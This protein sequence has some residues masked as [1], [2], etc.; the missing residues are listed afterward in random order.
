MRYRIRRAIKYVNKHGAVDDRAGRNDPIGGV[1]I[2]QSAGQVVLVYTVPIAVAKR[3]KD[4]KTDFQTITAAK[5]MTTI[6][7][8][9]GLIPAKIKRPIVPTKGWRM[10]R[11]RN[12]P[13]YWVLPSVRRE[14]FQ[15]VLNCVG[16]PIRWNEM[17][18]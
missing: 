15:Y 12:P 3:L 6:E 9:I 5:A 8:A 4:L 2:A 14:T 18:W 11:K 17:Q 1:R 13:N 7:R 16:G 10:Q